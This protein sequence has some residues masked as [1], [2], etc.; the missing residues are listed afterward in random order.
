MENKHLGNLI[1]KVK[2]QE[3]QEPKKYKKIHK[4]QREIKNY[5]ES[6]A[7]IQ[8][9]IIFIFQKESSKKALEMLEVFS[10]K[11]LITSCGRASGGWGEM[12]F[13]RILFEVLAP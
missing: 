6:V 7:K 3:R 8:K 1:K 10:E 2:F 4:D 12:F 5:D 9:R 11:L 13:I